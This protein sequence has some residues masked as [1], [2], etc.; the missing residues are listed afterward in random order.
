MGFG[1]AQIDACIIIPATL[2]YLHLANQ[3]VTRSTYLRYF[4]A[5]ER[6]LRQACNQTAIHQPVRKHFLWLSFFMT[7]FVNNLLQLIFNI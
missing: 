5:V 1:L 3:A 4:P 2:P 6:K 7:I